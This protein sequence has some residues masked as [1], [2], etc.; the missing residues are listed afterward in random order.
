M[1]LSD[2]L[3]KALLEQGLSGHDKRKNPDTSQSDDR[4]TPQP[5][6]TLD[7][8]EPQPQREDPPPRADPVVEATYE[9]VQEGFQHLDQHEIDEDGVGSFTSKHMDVDDIRLPM[10]LGEYIIEDIQRTNMGIIQVQFRKQES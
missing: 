3:D 6:T 4:T 2:R 5:P 8:T 10:P 1:K 7:Y 9:T